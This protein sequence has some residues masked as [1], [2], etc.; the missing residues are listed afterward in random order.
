M[1]RMKWMKRQKKS[2]L[3]EFPS[4]L[5]YRMLYLCIIHF[6]FSSRVCECFF[7]FNTYTQLYFFFLS[8]YCFVGPLLV[9]FTRIEFSVWICTTLLKPKIVL[10]FCSAKS[11]KEIFT[12]NQKSSSFWHFLKYYRSSKTK[13]RAQW[14]EQWI[15]SSRL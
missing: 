5:Q 7:V 3:E 11:E 14:S 4:S 1:C 12:F 9:S 10:N 13:N 8:I 2:P 15:C 6:T